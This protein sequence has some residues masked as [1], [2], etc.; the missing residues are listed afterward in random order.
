MPYQKL[1]RHFTRRN[2]EICLPSDEL[3]RSGA[4]DAHSSPNL[5]R[6]GTWVTAEAASRKGDSLSPSRSLFSISSP[7]S[8]QRVCSSSSS[9]RSE[10][11]STGDV[12]SMTETFSNK[13]TLE[14][15][16]GKEK[17]RAP[18]VANSG[19]DSH[20]DSD[21]DSE[22]EMQ[23]PC[24][25]EQPLSPRYSMRHTEVATTNSPS[26]VV[27]KGKRGSKPMRDIFANN[28]AVSS[29]F[30]TGALSTIAF[31][32][33]EVTKCRNSL[34]DA[35]NMDESR[36]RSSTFCA[37]SSSITFIDEDGSGSE[38]HLCRSSSTCNLEEAAS[39]EASSSHQVL[40][41]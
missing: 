34:S 39:R 9:P 37:S 8:P 29:S 25:V 21:S 41:N 10:A 12:L 20:S 7:R 5:M 3:R 17:Q 16:I 6:T 11:S 13:K 31:V 26:P 19:E 23:I 40:A 14:E 27:D 4:S 35:L 32:E 30:S 28:V 15:S 18:G 38:P 1:G 2:T 22:E 36:S 33:D 24:L